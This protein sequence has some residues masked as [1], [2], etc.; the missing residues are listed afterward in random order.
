MT[1]S[2]LWMLA[3][4]AAVWGASYLFIK[5]AVEEIE[6]ALMTFLRLGVAGLLLLPVLLAR[7]GVRRGLGQLRDAARPGFTLGLVNAAVP[8]TLIAWGEK[9]IDSGIA[10]IA[11]ATVPL[12]VVLLAIRFRPSERVRGGRLVGILLGLVGVGVLAGAQP[13]GGLWAVAGTLAVVLASLAYAS[14]SL[15]GQLR[16]ADTPGPVLATASMFGG[17]LLVLPFAALQ[18]PDELPGW[19]AL[20]SVAA[21]AVLGTALAQLVL[22]RMLRLHGSTRTSLVTYLLPPTAVLYGALLLDERLSLATLAGLALILPAV[23][24]GSGALRLPRG[25]QPLVEPS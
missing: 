20:G 5:V 25:K 9:H 18:L 2:Y 19:R 13:D 11:N 6:P 1:R 24:L 16:V 23:A 7:T 15:Y 22:F 12:F 10:A 17:A 21:L 4:L 8:F 14:G 3:F